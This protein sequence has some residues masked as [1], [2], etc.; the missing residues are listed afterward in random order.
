M[1]HNGLKRA[2]WQTDEMWEEGKRW[3]DSR[4]PAVRAVI[5]EHLNPPQRCWRLR[6]RPGHYGL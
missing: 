3:F 6:D 4:P 5:V 1:T 2:P